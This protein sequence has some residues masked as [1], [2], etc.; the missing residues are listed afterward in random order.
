[1]LRCSDG[2]DVRPIASNE[3]TDG[4]RREGEE[5]EEVEHGFDL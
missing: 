1:M 5:A 4:T 2:R 3:L